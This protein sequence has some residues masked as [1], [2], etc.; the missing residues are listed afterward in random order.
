VKL[1]EKGAG[2]MKPARI[3]KPVTTAG[4]GAEGAAAPPVAAPPVVEAVAASPGVEALAAP[5]VV[6]AVAAP[7]AGEA[8]AARPVVAAEASPSVVENVESESSAK[9]ARLELPE[10]LRVFVEGL[11]RDDQ[12]EIKEK[13]KEKKEK[14]KK[15]GK[16]EKKD[17]KDKK[18]KKNK[19]ENND[20]GEDTKEQHVTDNEVA[21]ADEGKTKRGKKRGEVCDD[22]DNKSE[23][24]KQARGANKSRT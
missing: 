5:Q 3:I 11:P 18:D 8:G 4:V 6:E 9:A 17:K 22:E 20:K 23:P 7:P 10:P 24:K 13:K 16:K 15:E 12:G 14:E 2:G 21:E 1:V 19:K